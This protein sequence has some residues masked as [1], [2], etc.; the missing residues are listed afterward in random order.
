MLVLQRNKMLSRGL[1]CSA[2]DSKEH[3]IP[4]SIGG[5]CTVMGVCARCNN[6]F[7][8]EVESLKGFLSWGMIR[9]TAARLNI[10]RHSGV[11]HPIVFDKRA[12]L[13]GVTSPGRPPMDLTA[14]IRLSRKALERLIIPVVDDTSFTGPEDHGDKWRERVTQRL[15]QQHGDV[16]VSFGRAEYDISQSPMEFHMEENEALI[17]RTLAKIGL[18]YVSFALGH[19]AALGTA[20]D[21]LR[22]YVHTGCMVDDPFVAVTRHDLSVGYAHPPLHLLSL[23]Q[24]GSSMLCV[25]TIFNVVSVLVYVGEGHIPPDA[26][27]RIL[28]M[29][30]VAGLSRTW[31]VPADLHREWADNMTLPSL[32]EVVLERVMAEARD[33]AANDP[34]APLQPII[35]PPTVEAMDRAVAEADER[36]A[37]DPTVPRPIIVPPTKR[38]DVLTSL[39]DILFDKDKRMLSLLRIGVHRR[40]L[41]SARGSAP[42]VGSAPRIRPTDTAVRVAGW[43]GEGK[44]RTR[45]PAGGRKF[46]C[47]PRIA[48]VGQGRRRD[49]AATAPRLEAAKAPTAPGAPH[50]RQ[51][52]RDRGHAR[53]LTMCRS[54]EPAG[55]AGVIVHS[56]MSCVNGRGAGDEPGRPGGLG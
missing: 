53:S 35:L 24:D 5:C 25:M 45:P 30:P 52:G 34:S 11:P 3:I 38:V 27:H 56:W 22:S 31:H 29:D 33:R 54:M 36:A 39:H 40:R 6:A 28:I 18:C 49:A 14:N 37:T 19:E 55:V 42:C 46:G 12:T 7:G 20:F 15:R 10:T 13:K 21:A 32:Y 26:L 50:R 44:A 2:E 23:I 47:R 51:S 16:E 17:E 4:D 9:L 48:H 41:F 1:E 43:W 8:S